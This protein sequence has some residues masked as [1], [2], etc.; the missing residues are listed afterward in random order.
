P[1][2]TP[3]ATI[4]ALNRAFVEAMADPALARVLESQGIIRDL[5]TSP[6]R[7]TRLMQQEIAKWRTVVETSG[8]QLD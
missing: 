1:K 7:L 5:D 2:N 8:A 4:A 3:R 6:E